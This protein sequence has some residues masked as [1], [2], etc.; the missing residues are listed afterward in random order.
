MWKKR[1]VSKINYEKL[2]HENYY[3][4]NMDRTQ[5][6]HYLLL[7]NILGLKHVVYVLLYATHQPP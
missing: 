3:I 6:A 4:G 5:K 1:S 7:Y 2:R